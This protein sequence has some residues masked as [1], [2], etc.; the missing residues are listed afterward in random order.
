MEAF[1]TLDAG[2]GGGKCLIFNREGNVLGSHSERWS[3]EV[4]SPDDMPMVKE[5]SFNADEFWGVLSRC[6]RTALAQARVA[7]A[8]VVGVSGTSQREG[9]VFLNSNG[10][11]IYAGPNIDA[12]GFREGLEIL[13]TLGPQRLYEITGHSAPFIFPIARYLWFRARQPSAVAHLLMINDWI[14]W[15]LSGEVGAE[16]SNATESMLF[17]LRARNWSD[18][19]LETFE[20]PRSI[21]PPVRNPGEMLG[22]VTEAAARDTGLLAGTPV[23]VGGADTQCA[24]LGAGAVD[25][26]TTAATLGTTTPVQ[27]VADHAHFDPQSVLW[28]GCHVIPDR[29]V[30][31]SNA[32]DTGDAYLW[33][34]DV[35]SGGAARGEALLLGEQL[36][37]QGTGAPTMAFLGPSVFN[38][39][40]MA[41]NRP[42]GILFPFPTM[43]MRPSRAD[44][45]RSFMESVGFAIRAN[46]EQIGRVLA[47]GPSNLRLSGGM[48]RSAVLVQ[49]IC[50]IVGYPVLV[51]QQPDTAALGC[52]ILIMA[53]VGGG[54]LAGAMRAMSKGMERVP[55]IERHAAYAAPYVKWCELYEKAFDLEI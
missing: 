9:C 35:V 36:G 22:R 55:D 27:T 48:T 49:A 42:G 51:S 20:I 37:S 29:W 24:M 5:F 50:D 53:N 52:A 54:G 11:E 47:A 25:P 40:R 4:T 2:T 6:V 18:E 13:G 15:R 45:I 31:E 46:V 33:L 32:G 44:L 1:V 34:L 30:L 26:G 16:P 7:P 3:Y 19:I 21:L 12:R 23:F 28:A 17:D 41:L 38:L 43:H 39:N 14:T 10:K 8:D